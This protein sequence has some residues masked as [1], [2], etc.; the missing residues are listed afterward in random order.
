MVKNFSIVLKKSTANAIETAS[1][2]V[3]Q[4]RA[5]AAGD[6]I[7][8]KIAD[9][10]TSVSTELPQQKMMM[11]IVKQ[12]CQEKDIYLQKKDNKLLMN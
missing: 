2:R 4:K 1:K 3:I 5:E 12:K 9:K 8:N 10:L 6:L 11:L 7:G